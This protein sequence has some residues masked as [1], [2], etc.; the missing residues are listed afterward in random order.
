MEI[1]MSQDNKPIGTITI[2]IYP[3]GVKKAHFTGRIHHNDILSCKITLQRDY[4]QY[5][6]RL[7][8]EHKKEEAEAKRVSAE[9]EALENEKALKVQ[10]EKE[11]AEQKKEARKKVLEATVKECQEKLK[12][13][14]DPEE[15]TAL[16][17]TLKTS[18]DELAELK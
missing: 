5:L 18:R 2:E 16:R 17:A 3:G 8:S 9:K 14:G 4:A 13:S 10:Q 6:G 11:A 7:H 1:I 15:K 12:T